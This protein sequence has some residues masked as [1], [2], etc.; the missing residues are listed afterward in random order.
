VF[1]QDPSLLNRAVEIA[2]RWS[3]RSK[4]RV[5][6]LKSLKAGLSASS[7]SEGGPIVVRISKHLSIFEKG[8]V[9][10]SIKT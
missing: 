4:L 9:V 1:R 6:L 2:D 3:M 10:A 8:D 7:V 5:K